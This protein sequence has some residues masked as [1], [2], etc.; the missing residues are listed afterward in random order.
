[1]P[2]HVSSIRIGLPHIRIDLVS[3]AEAGFAT[4]GN[5]SRS[6]AARVS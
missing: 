6:V 5:S 4:A 2:S 1:M 3:P